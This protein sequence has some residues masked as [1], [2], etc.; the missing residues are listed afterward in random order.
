MVEVTGKT[1]G[2]L[3]Q[4]STLNDNFMFL[5][6]QGSTTSYSTWR[7]TYGTLKHDLSAVFMSSLGSDIERRLDAIE[8]AINT[9][10]GT[11]YFKK[12]AEVRQD[13]GA[14]SAFNNTVQFNSNVQFRR[15]GSSGSYSVVLPKDTFRD[16]SGNTA[17]GFEQNDSNRVATGQDIATAI[18]NLRV[19]LKSSAEQILDMSYSAY[20]SSI[21]ILPTY[22]NKKYQYDY[23]SSTPHVFY[24][25]AGIRAQ[26]PDTPSQSYASAAGAIYKQASGF[27]GVPLMKSYRDFKTLTVVCLEDSSPTSSVNSAQKLHSITIPTFDLDIARQYISYK[28]QFG[29]TEQ[30]TSYFD[31]VADKWYFGDST[32]SM[33]YLSIKVLDTFTDTFIPLQFSTSGYSVIAVFG[34]N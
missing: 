5:G 14:Q 33:L 34:R 25:Y 31:N 3:Q 16:P 10:D 22:T 26:S 13:V 9:G 19:E 23:N 7:T 24:R 15:S 30:D 28:A 4:A 21:K 29:H 20:G 17:A 2:E 6:C 27:N 11:I 32:S 12:N 8:A 1:I 18:Q